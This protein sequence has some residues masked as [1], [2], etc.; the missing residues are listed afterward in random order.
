MSFVFQDNLYIYRGPDWDYG[1]APVYAL[2]FGNNNLL[3]FVLKFFLETMTWS[4][5]SQEINFGEHCVNQN[6]H[7]GHL[8]FLEEC[9]LDWNPSNYDEARE[10]SENHHVRY[11]KINP[12]PPRFGWPEL[13]KTTKISMDYNLGHA[14]AI[15]NNSM[16]TFATR[17]HHEVGHMEFCMFV[18]D[19]DCKIFLLNLNEKINRY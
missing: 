9:P 11:W 6:F 10:N 19:L 5:V 1:S 17:W 3:N 14:T 4:I 7:K 2:N 12:N 16:V 18:L 15:Y 8:F 13:R